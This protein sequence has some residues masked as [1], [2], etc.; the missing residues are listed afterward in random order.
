MTTAAGVIIGDEILSGKVQETNAGPLIRTMSGAGVT[1]RRIA[2][3]PDEPELIAA[4]VRRCSEAYDYVVTSGGVGPTHDD[5]TMQGVAM[6]F[7]VEV[8]RDPEIE[9]MVRDHWAE[10]VNDA[11]LKL[12]Q[13]PAG[14]RLLHSADGLLPLVVFRN[15]FILPGIPRLFSAKL[16]RVRRELQGHRVS[17]LSVYLSTDESSI[18]GELTRLVGEFDGVKVGSYPAVERGG[19]FR[20]RVTVEGHDPDEVERAVGRL[21]ELLPA[22]VVLRVE[23]DA[24]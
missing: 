19:D 12:A 9:R 13:L 7:G 16:E 17:V 21:T 4:E 2:V 18:A 14:G 3:I 1:L 15:V 11:A 20:V 24:E 10:R 23:R 22:E 6:A 8:V 5:C